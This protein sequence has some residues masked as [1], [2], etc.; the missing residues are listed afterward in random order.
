MATIE[1]V[2]DH[3]FSTQASVPRVDT[4]FTVYV[5][6]EREGVLIEPGP[7]SAIPSIQ[8]VM[9]QLGMKDLSYIIPTHIHLDHAGAI[10]SL[11]RLFPRAKVLLHPKGAK[12]VIEPTRLIQSTRM[13]FGEDFEEYYGAILPVPK[14]QAVIPNDGDEICIDARRLQI[15]YAPGHAPHHM[16]IFDH[17]TKGLFAGEALGSPRSGSKLSPLPVAAPPSFDMV[18]YLESI[19]KLRR[20]RPDTLFYSHDG[21]G[22]D[23][24]ELIS[25]LVENTKIVGDM[26]LK[27]LKEEPSADA[28]RS[29]LRESLGMCDGVILDDMTLNGFILYFQKQGLA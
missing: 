27:A 4:V 3:I 19:E 20:L 10:G 8:A 21:V 13:A 23:P 12:H 9:K 17:K 6:R 14:P 15:I 22:R 2:G 7:T 26:I 29:K 11:A 18:A 25:R 16:A 24:E 28:V 1:E 5:I